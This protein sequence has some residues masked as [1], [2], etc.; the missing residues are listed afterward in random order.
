MREREREEEKRKMERKRY[1][2]IGYLPGFYLAGSGLHC[3]LM[4]LMVS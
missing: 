4:L 1:T 2:S 3:C